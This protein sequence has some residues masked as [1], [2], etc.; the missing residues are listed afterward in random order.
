[1]SVEKTVLLNKVERF[2]VESNHL[3]LLFED[4]PKRERGHP[5]YYSR[6]L[7]VGLG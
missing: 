5:R 4:A 1:M 6:L 7:L 3:Y 2:L